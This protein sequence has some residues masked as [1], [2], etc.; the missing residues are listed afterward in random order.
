MLK[1][2]MCVKRLP[3]LTHEQ[4]DTHWREKHGPLVR[5]HQDVLGIRRYVQTIPLNNSAA[6][7]GIQASRGTLA[8]DFDGCAELWWDSLEDHIAARKTPEGG[9][10][11]QVLIEDERRFVDLSQSQLW[12]GKERQIIPNN[13][14]A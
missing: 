9:H 1:L 6:Q 8:V 2:I 10:A 13:E 5:T 7:A 4:F 11:L 12:Y 3:N 14:H